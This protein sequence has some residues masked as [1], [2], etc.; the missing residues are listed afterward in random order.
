MERLVAV[1]YW[2]LNSE[3]HLDRNI[4]RLK[5]KKHKVV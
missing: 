5:E 1:I 2:L 3:Q 4:L